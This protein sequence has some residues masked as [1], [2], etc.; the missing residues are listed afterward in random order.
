M[1]TF[2]NSE[3][4]FREAL[5]LM[6][7]G[8]NS[9]VRAFRGISNHPLFM[10]RGKGSHLYDIDDNEFIDY[11]LSWGVCIHGHAHEEILRATHNAID[12]GT[13]FGAPTLPESRLARLIISMVPSIEKLRLVN[14]GTEA[15]MS[16]VRL[17]RGFTGRSL[18]VKFDGCYHGHS[19]GMLISA[20]SGLTDIRTSNSLG[21]TQNTLKD[22]LSIPFN[23]IDKVQKVFSENRNEIAAVIL[24]PVP[25]NMGLILPDPQF[26]TSLRQITKQFGALLI[27]DEVISGFRVTAGGAQQYFNVLPDL[28]VLGKIIGGGFPLAA[29]GGSSE[30]MNMV[31][32]AGDVY[33]AGTLSGNP[34]AVA[35]GI[36]AL[37]KI[38]DSAFNAVYHGKTKF[39]ENELGR[40]GEKFPVSINYLNGMFSLFFTK[41]APKNYTDVKQTDFSKFPVFYNRLLDSG[42]YFSP[43]YF[44]SNFISTAHTGLDFEN[45]IDALQSALKIIYQ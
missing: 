44:E 22:T 21:I 1:K 40:L 28:T 24:E 3:N 5:E 27:F 15:V 8:V 13:S 18:V 38:E 7:G 26:L 2:I 32:P 25:A 36:A 20:G 39:F 14:S 19:D 35:A 23:D 37:E 45:T 43:G 42:V 33:Q 41:S 9:P 12:L 4:A 34:V 6:P 17:A 29:Y 30:I 10:A 16:A 31:A 11:C